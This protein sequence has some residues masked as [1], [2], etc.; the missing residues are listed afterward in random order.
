MAASSSSK[1][2]PGRFESL[3]AI[4]EFISEAAREAGLSDREVY[5]VKLA[6]DEACS[7][8]IEHAYRGQ[9]RGEI[10]CQCA[11]DPDRLI[12]VLRDQGQRFDPASVP[13]PDLTTDLEARQ[14]GGLGLYLMHRLVDDVRFESDESGNTLILVKRRPALPSPESSAEG[15]A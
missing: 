13:E 12:I 14:T 2:F 10:E 5:A 1:R 8:I 3:E 7:N 11:I 6:V 4:R 9:S 15:D